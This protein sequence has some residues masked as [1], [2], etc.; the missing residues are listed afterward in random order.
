MFLKKL[1]IGIALGS[2]VT[3]GIAA[4]PNFTN[5]VTNHVTLKKENLKDNHLEPFNAGAYVH[6]TWYNGDYYAFYKGNAFSALHG[7]DTFGYVLEIGGPS[8]VYLT[9][10]YNWMKQVGGN[11][12][13]GMISYLTGWAA[14]ATPYSARWDLTGHF[15]ADSDDDAN[16][17]V[18]VSFGKSK[19]DLHGLLVNAIN[20][21]QTVDFFFYVEETI[22]KAYGKVMMA[23]ATTGASITT[24]WYW[25]YS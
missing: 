3:P 14:Y 19:A 16:E 24:D 23:N 9:S 21:K 12:D 6:S 13:G 4:I 8:I 17:V 2:V 10:S 15:Q 22:G 7:G 1:T 25:D 18:S 11:A 20:H 5:Q